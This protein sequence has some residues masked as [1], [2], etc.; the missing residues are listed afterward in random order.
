MPGQKLGSFYQRYLHGSDIPTP[1]VVEILNVVVV[2]VLP[3]PGASPTTKMCLLVKGQPEHLP[4]AILVGPRG[5]KVLAEI[6]GRV[7]LA[8]L[9]GKKLEIFQAPVKVNGQ[10]T[11]SIGFRKIKPAAGQPPTQQPPNPPKEPNIPF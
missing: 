11:F 1:M 8:S 10:N 3:H 6:F 7:E 4:G 2:E 5:E 9:K